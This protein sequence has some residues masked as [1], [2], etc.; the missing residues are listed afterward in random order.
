MKCKNNMCRLDAVQTGWEKREGERGRVDGQR[1]RI[2]Q[3]RSVAGGGGKQAEREE[4]KEESEKGLC[5]GWR[6]APL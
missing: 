6:Y 3:P 5:R 1:S 4:K 2:E